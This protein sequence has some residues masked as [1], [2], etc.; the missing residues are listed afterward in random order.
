MISVCTIWPLA[1]AG[2]GPA[3]RISLR[4]AFDGGRLSTR[5]LVASVLFAGSASVSES[6]TDAEFSI[7]D[8]STASALTPTVNSKLNRG[9]AGTAAKNA[10]TFPVSPGT[11]IEVTCQSR[12]A[13]KSLKTVP[14]GT[15]VETVTFDAVTSPRFSIVIR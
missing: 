9:P 1:A 6:E 3:S 4:L 7:V 5:V 11:G 2:L 8:P 15:A 14:A 13:L 12:G 10:V